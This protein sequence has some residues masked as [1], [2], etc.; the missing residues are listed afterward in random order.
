MR[1]VLE[2]VSEQLEGS[3]IDEPG[4]LTELWNA[5]EAD[6]HDGLCSRSATRQ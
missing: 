6:A 3:E 5:V 4:R 1:Q 2:Q